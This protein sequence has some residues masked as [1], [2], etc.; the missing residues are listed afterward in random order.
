MPRAATEHRDQGRAGRAHRHRARLRRGRAV[1]RQGN[2]RPGDRLPTALRRAG[3]R[4]VAVESAPTASGRPATALPPPGRCAGDGVV[5]RRPGR[6]RARPV[7]SA[8]VVRRRGALHQL[9]PARPGTGASRCG[10]RPTGRDPAGSW[11]GWWVAPA[12]SR[13]SCGSWASTRRSSR[14]SSSWAVPRHHR[15]PVPGHLG[16][17]AGGAAGGVLAHC[18]TRRAGRRLSGAS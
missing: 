4:L 17:A 15:R 16:R 14:R 18:A 2:G 1:Q 13:R 10:T 3:R 6:Q 7:R 9:V 11:C 5:R 12:R 8:H